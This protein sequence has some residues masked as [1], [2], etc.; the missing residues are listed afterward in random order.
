M[1]APDPERL[2]Q[3]FQLQKHLIRTPAK[4]IR[5]DGTGP[6]IDGMP[7]PP[8]LRLPPHKAPHF[9]DFCIVNPAYR[10]VYIIRV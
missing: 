5:Q 6:M 2:Q 3:R 4:D 8:L 7:E 9:I 10:D 1:K